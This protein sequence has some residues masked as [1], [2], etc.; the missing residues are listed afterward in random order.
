MNEEIELIES[1]TVLA[2]KVNDLHK[3]MD[4][5]LM[6]PEIKAY[7]RHTDNKEIKVYLE[8]RGYHV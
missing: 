4:I 7:V 6:Y 3:I 1:F 5:M 8:S 2:K